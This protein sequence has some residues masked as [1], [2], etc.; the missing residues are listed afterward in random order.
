MPWVNLP[1]RPWARMFERLVGKPEVAS[2]AEIGAE[3]IFEMR[4]GY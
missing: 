4:C 3:D 2:E 1:V